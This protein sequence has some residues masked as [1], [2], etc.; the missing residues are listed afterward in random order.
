LLCGTVLAGIVCSP[1]PVVAPQ[2]TLQH[3][4]GAELASLLQRL[5]G[6]ID[7]EERISLADRILRLEPQVD[8]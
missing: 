4:P 5:Q 1:R 6:T 3:S 7:T 8:E 2:A